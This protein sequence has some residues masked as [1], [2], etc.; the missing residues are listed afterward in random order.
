[1]T[2]H[3]Q[4]DVHTLISRTCE[5]DLNGEKKVSVSIIKDLEIRA[6]QTIQMRP[7]S[8]DLRYTVKKGKRPSEMKGR[9][10][11]DATTGQGTLG[12]ARSWKSQK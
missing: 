10:W 4:K 5:Y 11:S 7:K 9:D 3:F 12:A 8:N 6:P 1:M 2:D